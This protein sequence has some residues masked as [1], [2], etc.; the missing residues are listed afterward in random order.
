MKE[1][2]MKPALLVIDIQKDFFGID[3]ITARSLRDAIVVINNAIGLFREKGFPVVSVQ[4]IDDE[5]GLVPGTDGFD[6][7][8]ELNIKSGDIH[9]HKTYRNA[10]N[11]TQLEAELK[12]RDVDLL[13][14]TGF[15]AE[16]C[17]LSTYRGAED[18][19]FKPMMLIGS[20]AS[21]DLENIGFVENISE[22]LSF[23]ALKYLLESIG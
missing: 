9:I 3:N 11:K 13:I 17:V 12:K 21:G 10:F 7:P 8:S 23:K 4:H 19:D 5:D 18:L 1:E 14:I 20:L 6:L 16:N 2:K 15:C 22:R